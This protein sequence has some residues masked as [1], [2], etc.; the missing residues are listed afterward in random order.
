MG[1]WWLFN[2]CVAPLQWGL[3]VLELMMGKQF[4]TKNRNV[5]LHK[6]RVNGFLQACVN[7]IVG[8]S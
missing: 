7:D 1:K 2:M 6:H 5:V 4:D 8:I 3:R